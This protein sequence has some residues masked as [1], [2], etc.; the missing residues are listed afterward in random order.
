MKFAKSLDSAAAPKGRF[1]FF[2]FCFSLLP[3]VT[4]WPALAQSWPQWGGPGRNFVAE[5]QPLAAWAEPPEELWKQPLGVGHAGIAVVGDQL[6]THYREGDDEVVAALATAD[7]STRW[8]HRYTAKP[9]DDMRLAYGDGPH[10]TPLWVDGRIFTIG[11]TAKLHALDAATGE[12][13]WKR[14]LWDDELAGSFLVR[15][16]ASSALAY[17]DWILLPIG[18]EQGMVAFRQQDGEIAWRSPA[19]DNSQS[20][21]IMIEVEGRDQL[22]AFVNDAV[23]G[24]D[25]RDGQLLW[26]WEHPSGGAYNISTP[27]WYGERRLLFVSSAYGGGSRALRL[28]WQGEVATVEEAWKTNR[29]KIHF[30]NTVRFGDHLYASNGRSGGIMLLCIDPESGEIVWRERAIGRSS[31][32]V[33]GDRVIA[34]EESGRLMLLGLGPDQKSIKGQIQLVEGQTWTVPTVVGD[35]LYVRDNASIWAYRLPTHETEGS[36][37]P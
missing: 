20:S 1:V 25:P 4:G 11:L 37:T 7:G 6:V 3:V 15:G 23:Q 14:D 28:G 34:L 16:Y 29:I 27:V 2:V 5:G 8:T 36:P 24:I 33:V 13:L 22:V 12:L 31:L 9:S 17:R 18:G 26:T 21:P 32:V 35:R 30:T 19:F 10:A